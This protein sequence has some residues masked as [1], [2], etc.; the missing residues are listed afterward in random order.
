MWDDGGSSWNW[1]DYDNMRSTRLGVSSSGPAW[2]TSSLN[3]VWVQME[4]AISVVTHALINS[5]RQKKGLRSDSAPRWARGSGRR[6]S[7]LDVRLAVYT[8]TSR[9]CGSYW[10][11][12]FLP[13]LPP[14]SSRVRSA[15]VVRGDG[16][17]HQNSM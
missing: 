14:Y 17:H 9:T 6:S 2:S 7:G 11:R 10:G 3:E 12:Q 15:A 4:A 1:S 16:G 8:R 5:R 13:H